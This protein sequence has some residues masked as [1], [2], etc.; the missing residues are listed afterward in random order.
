MDPALWLLSF[1]KLKVGYVI[2]KNALENWVVD[3]NQNK[4]VAN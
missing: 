3:E 1:S 2:K 4:L